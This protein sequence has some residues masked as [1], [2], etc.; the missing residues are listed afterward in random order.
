MKRL[1]MVIVVMVVAAVLFSMTASAHQKGWPGKRLREAFPEANKFT[2]QQVTLSA[3]QISRIEQAIGEK[4]EPESRVPTFFPGL[5]KAGEKRGFVLF[6]DQ[7][8]ENGKIEMGVAVDT[9]GIIR[10]VVIYTSREDRRIR[11][12]EFLD[13]FKGK[14]MKDTLKLGTDLTPVPGAEKASQAIV[15][16]VRKVLLIKQEAF[17]ERNP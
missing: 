13:Q 16:G 12:P 17:G 5:N 8:G 11:Q 15:T 1:S 3:D 7:T 6:A 10:N 2:S 9:Q 14:S 4:L